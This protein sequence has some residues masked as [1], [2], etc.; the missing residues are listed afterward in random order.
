MDLSQDIA[1][2]IEQER[3]LRFEHFTADIA[4]QIGTQLKA[5]A[6]LRNAA[7]TIEI[8]VNREL[9]F[10]YAMPGTAPTNADWA[11]RK[12]NTVEL[13]HKSSYRVGRELERDGGTLEDR[14]GLPLRDH[15]VHGGSFP[16]MVLGLGC[17]GTV[18]VSGLP[19]REDHAMLVEVLAP[20][21]SVPLDEIKLD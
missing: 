3:R 9:V 20:L 14:M 8:R 17:V 12:R 19:Q 1:R 21:C 7:V 18:T 2:L 4:W 13:M 6:E 11:R 10:F 16:L 15:A 5:L